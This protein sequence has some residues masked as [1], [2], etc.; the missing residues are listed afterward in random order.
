MN[1]IAESQRGEVDE[2]QVRHA[3]AD[4]EIQNILKDPQINLFLKRLQENPQEAQKELM[5]SAELS[6]AVNKLMAAGILRTG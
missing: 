5:K 2:E 3:M 6:D 4:P 1:K